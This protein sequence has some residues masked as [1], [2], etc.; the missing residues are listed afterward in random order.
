MPLIEIT[1]AEGRTEEQLRELMR[2]V[3]NAVEAWGAPAT[4]IRVLVREVPPALWM[5]GGVTLAEKRGLH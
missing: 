5:A 1:V 2:G 4:S 3:H